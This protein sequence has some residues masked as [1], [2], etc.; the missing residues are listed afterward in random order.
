MPFCQ[1]CGVEE[2][3]KKRKEE[4]FIRGDVMHSITL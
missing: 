4:G 3:R 2:K 1:F